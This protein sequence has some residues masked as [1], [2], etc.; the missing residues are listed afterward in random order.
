MSDIS[1]L[2]NQY[3]QLVATSDKVNN[4]VI[5]FRKKWLLEDANNKTKYPKLSVTPEEVDYAKLNLVVFLENIDRLLEDDD[6]ASDFLPATVL[7]DYKRR[8]SVKPYLKEDLKKL[9]ELLK[10][11]KPVTDDNIVLLDAILSVLDNERG[12]LFRKLRTARG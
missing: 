7:H 12:I 8:L 11:N 4:S 3:N 9:I 2:S 10:E 1:V 5:T 6:S